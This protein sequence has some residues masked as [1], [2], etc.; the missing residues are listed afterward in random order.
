MLFPYKFVP[1]HTIYALQKW[2]DELF[3]DVWCVAAKVV[4]YDIE[5]LPADLKEI[6]LAIQNDDKIKTDY[7]YGP[8]EKVYKIF[9]G[10]DQPT[11]EALALA[12]RHNN[13]IED[14]CKQTNGCNPFLYSALTA[15]NKDLS[16]ELNTFYKSLFTD[17]IK[18]KVVKDKIGEM[19]SHYDDF[20]KL[21]DESKCP[22]CGLND[23]KGRHLS[24]R[25][26]YDHFLAKGNYPFNSIN[27][28]NLSPMCYDCNS[29]YKG[30][31]DFLHKDKVRRK[32]FY[33]FDQNANPNIQISIAIAK[34]DIASLTPADITLTLISAGQQSEVDAWADVFGIEERYK[35]KCLEKNDGKYWYEQATEEYE[36][37]IADLGVQFTK[38]QWIQYLINSA[39]RKPHANGNFIKAKYLEAC[40]ASGAL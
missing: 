16:N 18:L 15:I 29:S 36:N 37:V 17:V 38:E 10:F 7:L 8:I 19:D 28:K 2:M 5:L 39:K 6:T 30:A 22:F 24:K 3:L 40:K 35:A 13:S 14:L 33:P 27:F 1:N 31:K 34:S 11:K 12:F 20:V 4:D 21:N 32:A 25:D 23:I 9:Q 26:A